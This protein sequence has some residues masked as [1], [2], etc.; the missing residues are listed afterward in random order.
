MSRNEKA[1]LSP[2]QKTV[3]NSVVK[4]LYQ[5]GFTKK[6]IAEIMGMTQATV[7]RVTQRDDVSTLNE[8][9]TFD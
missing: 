9:V 7:T 2:L 1:K 3:R 4:Y 8:L 5:I 6:F